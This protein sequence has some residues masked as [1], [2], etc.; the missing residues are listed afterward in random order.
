MKLK[1][2]HIHSWLCRGFRRMAG[3]PCYS[4]LQGL[5]PTRNLLRDI[6]FQHIVNEGKRA[7]NST[8]DS[9][10]FVFCAQAELWRRR[11]GKRRGAWPPPKIPERGKILVMV[12]IG[13]GYKNTLFSPLFLSQRF[14]WESPRGCVWS[15]PSE[16][17]SSF[18]WFYLCVSLSLSL[19]LSAILSSLLSFSESV[20]WSL[21]FPLPFLFLYVSLSVYVSRIL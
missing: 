17:R 18:V 12:I 8:R 13:K 19:V 15:A 5:S 16:L 4:W 11:A 9:N 7:F 3:G 1:C 6:M 20:F 21:F 14:P 2:E 10:N